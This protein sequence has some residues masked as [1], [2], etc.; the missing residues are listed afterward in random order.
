MEMATKKSKEILAIDATPVSAIE[1]WSSSRG[2]DRIQRWIQ[3]LGHTHDNGK[4]HNWI[5]NSENIWLIVISMNYNEDV[6]PYKLSGISPLSSFRH[7]DF[8]KQ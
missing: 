5:E 2:I 8:S 1:N 6:R 3:L 7:Q 4:H